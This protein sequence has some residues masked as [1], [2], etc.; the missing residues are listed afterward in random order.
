ME[1]PRVY[2]REGFVFPLKN[3]VSVI[4]SAT[5]NRARA[6]EREGENISFI[7]ASHDIPACLWKLLYGGKTR[8]ALS[9][10]TAPVFEARRSGNHGLCRRKRERERED[11][12]WGCA[13]A[14]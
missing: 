3:S 13:E 4:T 1:A 11:S 5:F 9:A 7:S 12:R 2:E 8:I 10:N 14:G 6:R